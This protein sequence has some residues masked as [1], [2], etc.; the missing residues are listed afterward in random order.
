MIRQNLLTIVRSLTAPPPTI[1]C[2]CPDL[3]LPVVILVVRPYI[4][5]I[6][7]N[8]HTALAGL[9][10]DLKQPLLLLVSLLL[11]L[12]L[13]LQLLLLAGLYLD[14]F[15]ICFVIYLPCGYGLFHFPQ[16][17]VQ[18]LIVCL[19]RT[20]W[21]SSGQEDQNQQQR[22][23]L[24]CDALCKSDHQNVVQLPLLPKR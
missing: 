12:H 18:V 11:L 7:L 22:P 9:L 5:I 21:R 14:Y 3:P 13:L 10:A 1:K 8:V 16:Y 6:C 24:W 20:E 2:G 15:F 23:F 17:H 19:Q 4:N